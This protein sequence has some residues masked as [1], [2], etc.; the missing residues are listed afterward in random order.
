VND[1]PTVVIAH[2]SDVSEL[3]ASP[4][5]ATTSA[6]ERPNRPALARGLGRGMASYLFCVEL[7]LLKIRGLG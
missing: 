6:T 7:R 4:R 2:E 3:D 1:G 5:E